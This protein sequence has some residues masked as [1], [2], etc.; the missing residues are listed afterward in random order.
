M[1]EE[2]NIKSTSEN[3]MAGEFRGENDKKK[4]KVGRCRRKH[5]IRQQSGMEAIP[6]HPG[7]LLGDTMM[8]M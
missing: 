8:M 6:Q 7:N 4:K 3:E 2:N 5:I 1:N